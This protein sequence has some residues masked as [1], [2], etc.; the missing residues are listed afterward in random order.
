MFFMHLVAA[1]ILLSSVAQARVS[2]SVTPEHSWYDSID[3]LEAFGC[4]Y[5]TSRVLRP[6]SFQDL[7]D[8]VYV[9]DSE[10]L[11]RAPEWL[12]RERARL[13]YPIYT[14]EASVS[15]YF[16]Q[17]DDLPLNGIEGSNSTLFPQRS[18]RPTVDGGN[19]NFEFR[20]VT[21]AGKEGGLGI[22]MGATPGLFAGLQ[23]YSSLTG[24]GY[25]QEAFITAGYGRTE[26][27]F[28]RV[29]RQFGDA[30]HGT[31]LLSRASRPIDSLEL[32]V[33]PHILG[34][35]FG[36]LGPVS[37]RVFAGNL[38]HSGF[39]DNARLGGLA[40]SLRP[41]PWLELAWME[42]YQFGG[43][44]IPR[45][46]AS[47][48]LK[49]LIY[50]GDPL[51]EAKRSRSS[52]FQ[53]S[54]REP[55]TKAKLY[56]QGY[57]EGYTGE[58]SGL[59]GLWFPKVGW[60]DLR[61]ELA[62]TAENAYTHPTYRQGLTREGIALGHPLGPDALG[63]YFD[64]G[65]PLFSSWRGELGFSLEARDRHPAASVAT[66]TRYGASLALKRNWYS[67]TFSVEARSH[68][69]REAGYVTGQSNH[70]VSS[71]ATLSYNFF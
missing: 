13:F 64:F 41:A 8:A 2:P 39:V 26:L 37:L 70:F 31:L 48:L 56:L 62:Y 25:L 60:T 6:Q 1:L 34:S 57:L 19:F 71:L 17:N 46:E 50:S 63:A 28:G 33:R 14:N 53:V 18:A 4:A 20:F 51:L 15:G 54:L 27:T 67:T 3:Q 61:F 29:A 59:A 42:L 52:V 7:R 55:K 58:A 32:V 65:F 9:A 11:C 22:A 24:R 23:N 21:Q 5:A 45:L 10:E 30:R 12:L 68:F 44:G 38:N 66:E 43:N 69:A 16:H 40:L 36:F 35:P 47:D 49:L